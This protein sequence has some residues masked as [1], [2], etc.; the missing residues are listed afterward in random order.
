MRNILLILSS[1]L[2]DPSLRSYFGDIPS[3][4]IP[5]KR[6]VA[7][8]YIYES[9]QEVYDEIFIT[10]YAKKELIID[11]IKNKNYEINCIE[12]DSL[13]DL[14]YSIQSFFMKQPSS[15]KQKEM[16]LTIIFADTYVKDIDFSNIINRNI[17]LYAATP[18]SKRWTTFEK[19]ENNSLV[20]Y[21]KKETITNK[22]MYNSFV[23]IFNFSNS[24][25]LAQCLSKNS[26]NNENIDSFYNAILA[27]HNTKKIEF[28]KAVDW[29]DMGHFDNYVQVKN[30][31]S[32][33]CFNYIDVNLKKGILTKKSENQQKLVKEIEWY[34]KLPNNLAYY[35]PRI[36]DFSLEFNHVFVEMEY[37]AY[38]TLHEMFIY[39]NYSMDFWKHV[40]KNL[41]EVN[42]EFSKYA[43]DLNEEEKKQALEKIYFHKT[44]SRLK[45]VSKNSV[46][47]K[48]FLK[49]FYINHK[50]YK[51]L[52]VII[53][54]LEKW[55]MQLQLYGLQKFN[56]IHGDYFFA[57][58]LFEPNTNIIR[59][60][61]PRGDFGG[62]G[63]Y[64]DNRYE[65]AKLSHSIEGK[66]DFIVEDLFSLNEFENKITYKINSTSQHESIKN[67]FYE[68]LSQTENIKQI[69][70][71][72]SLLFLSMIPLHNDSI[73]RQKV[74]MCVG[75]EILNDVLEGALEC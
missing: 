55:I 33:R 29:K 8:D 28:V 69:R 54:Y 24:R 70:F 10:V 60:I 36:F 75:V 42:S 27:Y 4:L 37:Y 20:I 57:N 71:I 44:I 17:A 14:G 2:V 35:T 25:L 19:T 47:E 51:S 50:K 9:A 39:G 41:F 52:N 30:T 45:K 3:A 53:N 23:G 11:Y 72:E 16:N 73:S 15:M 34:L 21:D 31:I 38:P 66:Y 67:V 58:I 40:L 26:N 7:L 32:T 6:K 65:M 22:K 12:L 13:K 59:L 62:F 46:F 56:I 49:N 18:D 48:Y 74:M 68:L 64:G 61:D 63:I 43:L 5:V 1:V